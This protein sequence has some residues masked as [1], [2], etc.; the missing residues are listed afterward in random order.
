MNE[1]LSLHIPACDELWYRQQLMQDPG[2]MSYNKGYDL[3]FAGY[4]KAT[5]CIDFPRED[6][7]D[8]HAY[9]V[10]QE[11]KRFYAYIIRQSDGAFLGEVN[12]HRNED[13]HWYEMGIVLEAK[14]R[15]RGYAADALG[16]LLRH[17]FEAM[18][19]DAVHNDFEETRTAAV[20]AHL[21]AGFSEYRRKNGILEL[22]ITRE[23][24]FRQKPA[25]INQ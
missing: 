1:S 20:R 12:V 6:W 2:T 7:A 22:L 13:A 19:A 17:A 4:D 15:G 16:L 25:G 8:W 24:Y 11:P 18:D 5:G 3:N 14:H 9:F 21:S 23:Q 10:G